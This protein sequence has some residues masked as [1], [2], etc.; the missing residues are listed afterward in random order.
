MKR[1]LIDV[2]IGAL[3]AIAF[4]TVCSYTMVTRSQ[5]Y[6]MIK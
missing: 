4:V 3:I 2:L 5:V 6:R 1:L